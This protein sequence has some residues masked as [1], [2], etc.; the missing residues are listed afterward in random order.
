MKDYLFDAATRLFRALLA[1]VDRILAAWGRNIAHG[2]LRTSIRAHA[3]AVR[4]LNKVADAA[5]ARLGWTGDRDKRAR[6]GREP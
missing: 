4:R 6:A 1:R 5:R 3:Y 2:I